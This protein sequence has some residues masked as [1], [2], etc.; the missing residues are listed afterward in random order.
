MKV[1]TNGTSLNIAD[2]GHGDTTL[3]FLHHWGGSSRTWSEV[4]A[5]LSDRF[6]CVAIDARGA[7]DSDAPATGYTTSDHADDALGV[8]ATLK[9]ERYILVGH[10]MGGKA[11][12][13]L[14]SRRPKGLLGVVLVASSP[15]S[16]MAIGDE[17]R[18]Q[19][20][21]AYSSATSV[22]WSLDNVLV[23]SPIS[24]KVRE[25]LVIDAL[26]LSPPAVAGWIDVGGRE[27]ISFDVDKIA[28]PVAIM[29]GTIDHVDTPEIVQSKIV[30]HYPT[31]SVHMLAGKGHLLPVEAP[32]EI[33]QVVSEFAAALSR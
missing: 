31:A 7:G 30:P 9:L 4:T 18:A 5:A 14:A 6:R 27:D 26:R 15:P 29:A 28:V 16:P 22:N 13:L 23:G 21:G 12:Q 8:I 10:S 11:A 24:S 19:M 1:N 33:V 17:Q 2:S 25:Q 32:A 20:K 3:V